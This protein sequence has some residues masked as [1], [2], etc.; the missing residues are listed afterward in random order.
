MKKIIISLLLL[1]TFGI[2]KSQDTLKIMTFNCEF[3]WDGVEPEEGRI[4][5]EH[6]GD[7][8]KAEAHMKDLAE[9][10]RRHNPH[11]VNLVETEGVNAVETLN[12]KFLKDLGYTVYFEKGI[13]SYTGQDVALLSK[14]E[15]QNFGRYKEASYV[16]SYPKSVSKNYFAMTEVYGHKI[17]FISLHFLSQP[18]EPDRVKKRESQ[19][20][21][22]QQLGVSLDD[23]GYN[24]VMFGDFND[25]DGDEDCLDINGNKPASMVLLLLKKLGPLDKE[26]DLINVASKVKQEERYTAHYDKNDD[27]ELQFP[28]EVSAIDHILISKRLEDNIVKVEYDHTHDP[29]KVSDHFPIITT[30]VF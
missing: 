16:G 29:T 10:I 7:V 27:G 22:M 5:F 20:R 18:T 8:E 25:F 13:D 12:N 1:A 4:E 26:D 17:A 14:V 6:K 15:I 30:L 2:A 11:I 24:I 28:K 21:T 23:L 19:M 9:V 3:M